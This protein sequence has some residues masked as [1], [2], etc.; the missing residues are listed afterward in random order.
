MAA[1]SHNGGCS[2][3]ALAAATA[4][5]HRGTRALAR[6]LS[7]LGGREL[8]L[9]R[10]QRHCKQWSKKEEA[11]KDEKGN[12]GSAPLSIYSKRRPTGVP[13]DRR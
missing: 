7:L 13:H 2:V 9:R 4:L 8:P 3:L 6:G 5:G 1:E 12:G 10:H 11:S